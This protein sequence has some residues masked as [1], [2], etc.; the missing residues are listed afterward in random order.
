MAC[1]PSKLIRRRVEGKPTPLPF[2]YWDKGDLAIVGRT[3]TR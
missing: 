3:L 1:P 2:W